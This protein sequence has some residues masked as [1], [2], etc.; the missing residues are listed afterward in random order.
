MRKY[1]V[2]HFDYT[3]KEKK[4][5]KHAL[6]PYLENTG[7]WRLCIGAAMFCISTV[8]RETAW[9]YFIYQGEI[10]KMID[11]SPLNIVFNLGMLW[12]VYGQ[13]A[14]SK[15]HGLQ[16]LFQVC[17]SF[18][19]FKDY[20]WRLGCSKLVLHRRWFQII[21]MLVKGS[22]ISDMRVLNQGI[23]NTHPLCRLLQGWHWLS[24]PGRFTS[25]H[26]PL[27]LTSLLHA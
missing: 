22:I 19:L 6:T 16:M 4:F 7:R 9:R 21:S 2:E 23:F 8:S 20:F 10:L 17:S 18:G 1:V 12:R 15:V 3:K 24:V 13:C 27:A 25:T 11:Q 26:S 14:H 5:L